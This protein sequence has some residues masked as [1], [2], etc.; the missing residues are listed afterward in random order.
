MWRFPPCTAAL[1]H[2]AAACVAMEHSQPY[3][4]QLSVLGVIGEKW[5]G[6][7][8]KS[9]KTV[10]FGCAGE[11]C[12]CALCAYRGRLWSRSIV[13]VSMIYMVSKSL[14]STSAVEM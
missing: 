14:A 5:G 13:H 6:K 11:L 10:Q 8:G 2:S 4:E 3:V 1:Q 7:G 12:M 9:F